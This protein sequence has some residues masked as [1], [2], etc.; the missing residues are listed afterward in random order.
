MSSASDAWATPP[1]IIDRVVRVLGTIDLDPAA[2]TARTVPADHY[3]QREDDALRLPWGS[4]ANPWA[5]FLNPPYGRVLP[6]F[7][8]HFTAEYRTG[9]IREAILLL[10]ART[11]TA[12]FQY[13]WDMDALCFLRGRLKFGGALNGAPFPSCLAY[14]GEKPWHFEL[15]THDLGRVVR[16]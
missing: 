14:A 1:E 9:H 11:D 2:D 15:E 10:P 7:L 6:R 8:S 13:I 12:W 16:L 5:I 4:I 3:Y